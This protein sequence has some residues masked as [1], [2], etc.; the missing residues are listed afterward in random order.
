MRRRSSRY[1]FRLY[2][3]GATLVSDKAF[4]RQ[5]L[6]VHTRDD[7]PLEVLETEFSG[8]HPVET[9]LRLWLSALRDEAPIAVP[10]EEGMATVALAEA[11]YR[12]AETGQIVPLDA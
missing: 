11:A 6:Q 4:D 3:E 1:G 12:S 8:E 10:G 5:A 9:E 2:C 7:G